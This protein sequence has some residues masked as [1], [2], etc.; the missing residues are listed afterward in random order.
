QALSSNEG[1]LDLGD[2]FEAAEEEMASAEGDGLMGSEWLNQVSEPIS[3]EIDNENFADMFNQLDS[4]VDVQPIP[5][6]DDSVSGPLVG[7]AELNS[8]ASLFEGDVADFD[9]VWE[10]EADEQSAQNQNQNSL[11][12]D[13]SDDFADLLMDQDNSNSNIGGDE[14]LASLFG[15][16][17]LED[18][19]NELDFSDELGEASLEATIDL[20]L[21]VDFGRGGS[22]PPELGMNDPDS[23][24]Q[25]NTIDLDFDLNDSSSSLELDAEDSIVANQEDLSQDSNE[26]DFAFDDDAVESPTAEVEA[27]GIEAAPGD[28]SDFDLAWD[29]DDISDTDPDLTSDFDGL[30]T[31]DEGTAD[32]NQLFQTENL[33]VNSDQAQAPSANLDVDSFESLDWSSNEIETDSWTIEADDPEVPA[34]SSIDYGDFAFDLEQ[35]QL[36]SAEANSDSEIEADYSVNGEAFSPLTSSINSSEADGENAED[37]FS[38]TEAELEPITSESA[39]LTEDLWSDTTSSADVQA[40]RVTSDDVDDFFAVE[41]ENKEDKDSSIIGEADNAETEDFFSTPVASINEHGA[42]ETESVIAPSDEATDTADASD[43][44]GDLARN[45]EFEQ[46]SEAISA[47]SARAE[48]AEEA[49]IIDDF[50]RPLEDVSDE[51]TLGETDFGL[52][53]ETA[54]EEDTANFDDLDGLLDADSSDS[55][56]LSEL[57]DLSISSSEDQL[58]A[59]EPFETSNQEMVSEAVDWEE[60]DDLIE[61]TQVEGAVVPE[62]GFTGH[63]S[64]DAA[65]DDVNFDSIDSLLEQDSFEEINEPVESGSAAVEEPLRAEFS[66]PLTGATDDEF[67]DLEKLLEEADQLGGSAPISGLRRGQSSVPR[68]IPRR[69][70]MMIDQTMRVS[71]HHLDNLS[72]L[73]GELV[74]NRN[75]LEGDQERLRQFLENLLFQVQQLNDVGQRMR[76]LYERSLLESSL[77]SS[78]QAFQNSRITRDNG[79]SH[80]TGASFDALEMDRFTGFHTLTQEMIELIVR[81]R[82]SASDIGFTVESTDQVTR[83]FRQVTTQLQEGL[84]KAR[85]VPFAQTADRLPRAVRDI[86]LKCGKEA[87]LVVEGRDTLIDK[88]ILERL[89]DP[90]THL[91]NN[92]ITHGIETPEERSAAGKSREGTITVRAFYQGNQTVIYIADDGGGINSDLVREKALARGIITQ[93]EAREMSE[94]EIYELLFLPGFSTRDHADDF[95]GRG[96]GMDVV[97]TTLAEIRGAVTVDSELGRGTSFTIRLPL[98]LSI[99]KALS[100]VNNQARIAFPMDG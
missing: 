14:D 71:V 27:V 74:V 19:D 17:L 66:E 52:D 39:D 38:L 77:I 5:S 2:L 76:D 86:S 92:A 7:P 97:R 72:N 94:I 68:R 54:F 16:S 83:Q 36:E 29:E 32:F 15:A 22:E 21:D 100:C 41:S 95:A 43:D 90:M 37:G 65:N 12:A 62:S 13:I 64:E 3:E 88:M 18:N 35:P 26:L 75:S 49:N 1:E 98:T 63:V 91:V 51:Q 80:A 48:L 53:L 6:S 56:G 11:D 40:A 73:V 50:D 47:D 8:L 30:T 9:Q 89:Y 42:T 45:S 58:V 67:E 59:A 46:T 84:N 25:S 55:T 31:Y 93:T 87:K 24:S 82:E 57:D 4:S 10:E 44:L 23:E 20:E 69:S 85:M 78:R 34:D 61:D 60:L 70:N 96:V 81:V 33:A 79:S 99:S 28:L